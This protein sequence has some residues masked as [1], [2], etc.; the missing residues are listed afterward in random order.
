MKRRLCLPSITLCL[1]LSSSA[2]ADYLKVTRDAQV[3]AEPSRDADV[4]YRAKAGISLT[5]L[6]DTE[7]NGY[8]RVQIPGS[9]NSNQ[10]G[11]I[12]RTFV[13]RYQGA[14]PGGTEGT[15]T[16]GSVAANSLH[17]CSLPFESIK[18][19]HPIDDTC[20]PEG[21]TQ[22][23]LSRLQNAAKN[24][25]CATGD[26]ALLT[27]D[28]FLKPQK[29]AEDDNIPFGGGQSLP[30][31]RSVLKNLINSDS[32]AKVGEGTVARLVAFVVDAHYS[33]VSNGETVNCN[34]R[35][36]ESNDIHIMLGQSADAAAC[37]TVTA[38][39]SPHFRPDAW[40]QLAGLDLKYPVRITGQ[41]FFDASHRPCRNGRG[42]NPQRESI[43]EIHPVYAVDVCSRTTLSECKGD[44]ESV[45]SPLDKWL[46]SGE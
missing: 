33:N 24:N 37:D 27:F 6:E 30:K 21:K 19:N 14:S 45:W 42:A 43:W 32:G 12:Y 4:L 29:A 23:D 15:T 10:S 9:G 22:S 25:F 28:S 13:R 16:G 5:L 40:D 39:M 11:W 46:S 1:L 38:E 8:Y 44:D 7:T 26:P 18:A 35:G 41:L 34:L 2:W 17:D 3:K 31:Y 36:K 20:G